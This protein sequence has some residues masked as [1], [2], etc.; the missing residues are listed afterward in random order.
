MFVDVLLCCINVAEFESADRGVSPRSVSRQ[1]LTG[2]VFDLPRV[3]VGSHRTHALWRAAIDADIRQT[4]TTQLL[5]HVLRDVR[6][7]LVVEGLH[8]LAADLQI[9]ATNA[10][11]IL[12]VAL[13]LGEVVINRFVGIRS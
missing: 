2:F 4:I 5:H 10:W 3:R 1:E 7:D 13:H 9:E 6:H 12:L 8:A 11:V